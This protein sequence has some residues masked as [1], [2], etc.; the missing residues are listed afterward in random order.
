MVR[1]LFFKA[2]NDAIII[3]S[4]PQGI[5]LQL[6]QRQHHNHFDCSAAAVPLKQ[7]QQS[8]C[9]ALSSSLL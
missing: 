2:V 4:A 6:Q 9:P 8:L 1:F 7:Q 3:S 5:V